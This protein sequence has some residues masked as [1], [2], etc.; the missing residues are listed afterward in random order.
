MRDALTQTEKIAEL[1]SGYDTAFTDILELARRISQSSIDLVEMDLDNI[2]LDDEDREVIEKISEDIRSSFNPSTSAYTGE[3]S[4]GFFMK[5]GNEEDPQLEV[6]Y[7]NLC[8]EI[9]LYI[10]INFK[11]L[12]L[13]A[14][15]VQGRLKYE[16]I[17]D[18]V[19]DNYGESK[20]N[21]FNFG[22]I[23]FYKDSAD[24]K[25]RISLLFFLLLKDLYSYIKEATSTKEEF[26]DVKIK[27]CS[28]AL[29]YLYRLM[30]RTISHEIYHVAQRIK[31]IRY[32]DEGSN[33][34]SS[35]DM[36]TLE[37]LLSI[38]ESTARQYEDIVYNA[39]VAAQQR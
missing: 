35:A 23:V 7:T 34:K 22:S 30:I 12:G 37:Y 32:P 29:D 39:I 27:E 16:F 9:A 18:E 4:E 38:R 25:F 13:D 1:D 36:T 19:H 5:W 21:S 3:Y 28:L 6:I 33:P 8:K 2:V 31:G 24:L 26:D 10:V 14:K 20:Y 17:K 11:I 15:E